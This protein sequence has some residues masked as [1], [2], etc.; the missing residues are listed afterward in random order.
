MWKTYSRSRSR[1]LYEV[2]RS[3]HSGCKILQELRCTDK[4]GNA[5]RLGSTSV[6]YTVST[7][8]Q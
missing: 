8:R 4:R 3:D 2:R 7:D 1:G 5:D 6:R